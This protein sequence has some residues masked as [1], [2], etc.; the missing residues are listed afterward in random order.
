MRRARLCAVVAGLLAVASAPAA[1]QGPETL[2]D[3]SSALRG[4]D[5]AARAQAIEAL[6]HLPPAALADIEARLAT[7]SRRAL[8]GEASTTVLTE[9]RRATGSRRAD[10]VVDVTG[11]VGAVLAVRRDPPATHVAEA[12]LLA[13]SAERIGTPDALRLVPEALRYPGDGFVME[14]RRLTLRLGPA[15]AATVLRV[16]GHGDVHVRE[17][18]R[19]SSRRLGLEAPGTFVRELPPSLLGDVLRAYGEARIM[20]AMPIVGS[21]VAAEQRS[22]REA[23]LDGLR[24]FGRNAIWVVREQY[25]LRSGESADEAWSWERTLDELAQVLEEARAETAH[26]ALAGAAARAAEDDV[27]GALAALEP[28]LL[29]TPDLAGE[30]AALLL[31][32]LGAARL[33]AGRTGEAD[34]LFARALLVA[35]TAAGADAWR[36]RLGFAAAERALAAGVLD[37]D[38]YARAAA[39]DPTCE[40]CVSTAEHYAAASTG[41]PRDRTMLYAAAALLSVLAALALAWPRRRDE[42]PGS[43]SDDPGT[44]EPSAGAANAA[45]TLS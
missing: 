30:E 8:D 19:W 25:R 36:A 18:A 44:P 37:V 7:L 9:L 16:M 41:G 40:A 2:A 35:P 31:G 33:E 15:I 42:A 34:E 4:D 45:T 14:G 3:L 1:A 13:R 17:W 20:A 27:D 43:G 26:R 23:A 11:G 5:D 10:D 29:R 32:E 22:V 6:G 28:L 24:A 38:A 21:Y 12:L 39:L